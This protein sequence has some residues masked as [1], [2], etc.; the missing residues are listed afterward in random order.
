MIPGVLP[1]PL[2][3]VRSGEEGGWGTDGQK[4][5]VMKLGPEREVRVMM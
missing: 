4:K 3:T 5:R 1:S 2:L